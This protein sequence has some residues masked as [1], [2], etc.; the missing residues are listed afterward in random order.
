MSS[1][2]DTNDSSAP[3]IG[4]KLS[5]ASSLQNVLASNKSTP[6]KCTFNPPNP[7]NNPDDLGLFQMLVNFFRLSNFQNSE[8]TPPTSATSQYSRPVRING[9]TSSTS[10]ESLDVESKGSSSVE[11]QESSHSSRSAET[12]EKST[13]LSFPAPIFDTAGQPRALDSR[14][15]TDGEDEQYPGLS[16]FSVPPPEHP[17]H[18]T[19]TSGVS[20]TIRCRRPYPFRPV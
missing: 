2:T 14:L 15:Y 4:G 11:S 8:N 7:N 20:F 13:Y 17:Y 16:K 6:K 18:R 3:F 9:E 12:S 1:D 5:D 19:T 10:Q